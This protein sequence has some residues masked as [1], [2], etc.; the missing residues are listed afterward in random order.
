[1]LRTAETACLHLKAEKANQ[2]GINKEAWLCQ[3]GRG[4][5]ILDTDM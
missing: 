1:M 5:G 3:L 4:L 2:F